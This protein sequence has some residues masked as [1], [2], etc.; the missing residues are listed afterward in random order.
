MF[1]HNVDSK[2]TGSINRATYKMNDD[3]LESKLELKDLGVIVDNHLT[4]SNHIAAKV[5]KAN[6]IMGLIRRTFVFVNKHNFNL[7]YKSLVRPHIE[8]GNIVVSPFQKADINLIQNMQRRATRFIPEIN[9]L[10]YQERLEKLHLPTLAYRRFR[11]SII[12]TYK[13]LHN[14]YDGNCTNSLFDLK[15]SNKSGHKFAVEKILS[16]TSIRRNFFSLRIANLW[17]SLPENVVEAPSTNT[18]KNRFDRHCRE[19]SLLFD[20]HT[21]YNHVYALSTLLKSNKK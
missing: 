14:L 16:T 3:I 6:Q 7:L 4:F 2:S 19:R 12:E 17:N 13:I 1:Y 21:D 10:D 15:A 20:V 9:K 5:N 11:G 8:Y 18:F